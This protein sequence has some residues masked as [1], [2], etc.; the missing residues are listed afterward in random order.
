MD[1]AAK[2]IDCSS[3]QV[4]DFGFLSLLYFGF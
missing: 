4:S 1:D 2:L 3:I